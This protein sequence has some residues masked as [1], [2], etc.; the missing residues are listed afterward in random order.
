MAHGDGPAV[1]VHPVRIHIKRL[2]EAQHDRGEG[3]VHLK[4]VDI[5]DRHAG[6][7]QDF[8]GDRHGAGQHDRGVGTDLGGGTDAGARFQAKAVAEVAVA[9]QD[10]GGPID[11][12]AGIAG[13][14]DM[15]DPLQMRVFHQGDAVEAGHDLSHLFEAGLQ[16]PKALHV[17]LGAHVFVMAQNGQAVLI[18][19]GQHRSGE[20]PLFPGQGCPALAFHGQTVGVIAGEAVLGGDDVGAYAL[21]HEIGLH[22][23][24]G[25][26][27]NGGP[28]AAHGDAAHH[29]DPAR[30]IAVA[31][32]GAHLIGG[33]VHRLHPAGAEAVDR[34]PG[35]RLVKVGQQD[36][37][38]G[39]TAAL[40]AHLGDIPPDHILNRMAFQPVARLHRV[41]HAGRQCHGRQLVQAAVGA[42]P[43]PGRA[44]GVIDVGICHH[45]LLRPGRT[46]CRASCH[47][48]VSS[49]AAPKFA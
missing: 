19:D 10:R 7:P 23:Q 1:D 6:I 9:D 40:F 29:L 36:G 22:R 47:R 16:R 18:G 37:R 38:A 15:G 31:S 45:T 12:A 20:A 2:H 17:G 28:V 21:R 27:G 32:P 8:F 49:Q 35:D 14:V 25:V 43:A 46:D 39:K 5:A 3:L 41:Q 11:D 30:D 33:Q 34:Q 24:A 42:A 48:D 13:V 44:D 4:E 26:H